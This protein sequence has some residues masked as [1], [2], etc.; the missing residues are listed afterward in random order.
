MRHEHYWIVSICVGANCA[1]ISWL[2]HQLSA[3][4]G[5]SM[6]PQVTGDLK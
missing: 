5:S 4:Y 2:D 6:G 1:L 3:A